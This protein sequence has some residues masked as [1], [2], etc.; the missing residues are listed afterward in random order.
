MSNLYIFDFGDEQY[1]VDNS[2]ERWTPVCLMQPDV[3][4]VSCESCHDEVTE[5]MENEHRTIMC[6]NCHDVVTIDLRESVDEI[7]LDKGLG[8]YEL[9]KGPSFQAVTK[10]QSMEDGYVILKEN[11]ELSYWREI[12]LG[13]TVYGYS[14]EGEVNDPDVKEVARFPLVME[15]IYEPVT[16]VAEPCSKEP[17]L[18]RDDPRTRTKAGG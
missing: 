13:G 6:Y 7:L 14:Y 2:G 12:T 10:K 8:Q 4:T 1:M 5:A 15:V 9:R 16:P 18:F 11:D 17:M 3:K